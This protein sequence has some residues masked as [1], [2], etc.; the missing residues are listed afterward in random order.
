[1]MTL[2]KPFHITLPAAFALFLMAN[3]AAHATDYTLTSSSSAVTLSTG[4]TATI[5][6]H[7][8]ADNNTTS[9]W[10]N[11]SGDDVAISV[12]G[13]LQ[14]NSNL[15]YSS[16]NHDNL[17]VNIASGAHVV[18]R[19]IRAIDIDGS[20]DVATEMTLTNDGTIYTKTQN[21][22]S[23]QDIVRSTITNNASGLIT[24]SDRTILLNSSVDSSL[25]NYGS[26]TANDDNIT[27]RTNITVARTVT[28]DGYAI[29]ATSADNL[30]LT[31]EG[32]I[33]TNGRRTVYLRSTTDAT[34]TN[35]GTITGTG[36]ETLYV[37]AAS[38]LN[39]T[40]SGTITGS[41]N[42]IYGDD[43]E[44]SLITNQDNG[45]VTATGDMA[46]YFQYADNASFVNKGTLSSDNGS[47][48]DT[49]NAVSATITND[50]TIKTTATG[51]D[52]I[53]TGQNTTFTNN[54]TG[55]ITSTSQGLSLSAGNE[56]KNYGSLSVGDNDT[57]IAIT[58]NNNTI[59]LYDGASISGIISANS[60]T[61]GNILAVENDNAMSLSDNIT[62][63]I[64][65]TKT[66]E[67]TLSITGTQGYTG[68]TTLS[69]GVL[70]MNGTAT[71]STITIASAGTLG[72]SGTTGDIINNGTLA[73][74]NSIGTL[75]VTGDVTM[76]SG[77]VLEIE[78]TGDGS[79][80]KIIVSGTVTAD[81][82][83]KLV[84]TKAA[85]F[86]AVETYEIID[87]GTATGTFD[88]ISIRACG[89][90]ID[91]SYN[92]DGV[93]ITLTGCYAKRGQ[94]IDKL[95]NYINDL[96][97]QNPSAD[98]NSVL[99]ALEGLSGTDYENALGSLDIDAPMA[100]ATS[101]AQGMRSVNGFISQ[102]AAIQSSGNSA[103][104]TLRMMTAA[105]PL[106]TDN[107]LSV[108]ERLEAHQS[109]GM[110]VKGFGGNGEKKA[111]K[112]LGV[113]GYDYDFAGTSIGFD[114]E[115][116]TIKHGIA[117]TLQKGSVTSNNNQG[118]QDYETVM[119]NYQNTQ[120][121][122]DGDAL[123]LSTAIGVTKVDKKRTIKFGGINRTAKA[124]YQTYALD[125][126]A[127]YSFAPM[128]LGIFRNDL[129]LSF[130]MNYNTQES[131]HE[132]G[133]DSLNLSVD[134][135]HTAKARIGAENIFYWDG[136][137]GDK[138]GFLPFFSTGI[139]ATRYLTNSA[140][141]QSFAGAS[142]VKIVTDRDQEVF[143]EIGLGFVNI[144]ENDD[145]LRL[146]TK[147]KLSDKVTE[148]SASLDYNFKF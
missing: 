38:N 133:A 92:S 55:T 141:K 111:I 36:T 137:Q 146:L 26:I 32:T 52:Y 17:S 130:G 50:G 49:R 46:V 119:V 121:F 134:P 62:G 20:S 59:R 136:N 100:I 143:G 110:W 42:V 51:T 58:G 64:G 82:V 96:Y 118:Y 68:A 84:P 57:A 83:L 66:G 107:K 85:K 47:V 27:Y 115:S 43:L 9:N 37:E 90:D 126:A 25:I 24:S 12:T 54:A 2:P 19:N 8:G 144:E 60:G 147:A 108:K 124:D 73:P 39:L 123:T 127:N 76:N 4:D 33:S 139:F 117:L 7:F 128:R 40:N 29:A 99:T 106:S 78:V 129:A 94:A 35:S 3:S 30:T 53:L 93:T 11:V 89:A 14:G 81:G 77:S 15:I 45:T 148:Y 131:Y 135:K 34:V 69:D 10:I 44:D 5:A 97:E 48:I 31:N 21:A 113:S 23:A 140:I 80:D 65:L 138:T 95:E 114:L 88:S 74:G 71:G 63:A 104:Q 102:R 109:K 142:K 1:M 101:T 28:A 125:L 56:F 98:L 16:A 70:K 72:G 87:A 22:I 105:E 122:D 112:D 120:F 13:A 116:E 67:G 86:G 145:E 61:T 79:S 91:T 103:R 18:S 132:T 75:N 41:T 6:D